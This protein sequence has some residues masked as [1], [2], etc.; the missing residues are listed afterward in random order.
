M[1]NWK[2]FIHSL[3]HS[4]MPKENLKTDLEL[5]DEIQMAMFPVEGK[6]GEFTVPLESRLGCRGKMQ[7]AGLGT[8]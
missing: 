7:G 8:V 6:S 3:I 2:P 4:F 5:R 1:R